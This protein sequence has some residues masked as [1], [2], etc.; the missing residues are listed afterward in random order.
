MEIESKGLRAIFWRDLLTALLDH[1]PLLLYFSSC[2]S[3]KTEGKI[4]FIKSA[5]PNM[6]YFNEKVDLPIQLRR[7]E[8]LELLQGPRS[9]SSIHLICRLLFSH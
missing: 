9:L 5:P 8:L 1:T 3:A 2:A 7:P 4:L 6:T